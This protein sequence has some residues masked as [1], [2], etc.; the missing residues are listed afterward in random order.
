MELLRKVKVCSL[1]SFNDRETEY[2]SV[3]EGN[4]YDAEIYVYKDA[5]GKVYGQELYVNTPGGL[6]CL[7]EH[8]YEEIKD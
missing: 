7:E 3:K 6:I 4:T 1:I 5:T 2:R 8:E